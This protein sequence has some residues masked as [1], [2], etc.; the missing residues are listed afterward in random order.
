[1]WVSLSS[2]VLE[3]LTE[4][5][6]KALLNNK[7]NKW[8]HNK[9]PVAELLTFLYAPQQD[10][11]FQCPTQFTNRTAP[12]LWPTG[13]LSSWREHAVNTSTSPEA[14]GIGLPLMT[15]GGVSCMLAKKGHSVL[16]GNMFR[17]YISCCHLSDAKVR[18]LGAALTSHT[19]PEMTSAE[20]GSVSWRSTKF[21]LGYLTTSS[22]NDTSLKML[23]WM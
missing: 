10:S 14:R 20:V 19:L 4:K 8:L 2:L 11:Q 3:G 23:N 6:L 15:C 5:N 12:V 9:L 18:A 16:G 17:G 7:V 13:V 21:M 1:M 22:N